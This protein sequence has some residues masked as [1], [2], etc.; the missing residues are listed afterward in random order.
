LKNLFTSLRYL[1][2]LAAGTGLLWLTFRHQHFSDV[3]DKIIKADPF[4]VGVSLV[5]SI[6]SL[7]SRSMRW[8]Q[9]IVSIGYNPRLSSTF[10]ALMLGYLA[11]MALPRLGEVSRC[12][13]LNKSDDIPFDK[14]LGTVIVERVSDVI[15]LLLCMILVAFLEFDRLGGFLN[16]NFLHPMME[17]MFGNPLIT[18]LLVLGMLI[19]ILALIRLFRLTDAPA[20]V[21]KIRTLLAGVGEGL[22]SI[23]HLENKWS[24]LL[25]TL[26]IW[27][28]YIVMTYVCF[29][30]FPFS[31]SLSLS[32]ALFI[33]V[34]GGIGMSAPVQGGIGTYDWLVSQGLILYGLS[35]TD[36]TVFAVMVHGVQTIFM[37][38]LGAISMVLL[39]FF[40]KKQS[41][42]I[43]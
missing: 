13:A 19:G 16:D 40:T 31:S 41:S 24:F 22:K 3:F 25:H 37:M 36:G 6:L 27:S 43:K 23:T 1:L 18:F 28:T 14:L 12:G 2:F 8:K 10:K 17:K 4:W 9:L 32:A 11:N 34:L 39:F 5:I 26:F 38:G 20:W 33:T 42:L 21:L 29:Y 35:E 15:M 30:A 7:I